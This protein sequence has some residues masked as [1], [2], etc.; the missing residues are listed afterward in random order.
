MVRDQSATASQ[1]AIQSAMTHPPLTSQ[2][3]LA[4]AAPDG[5]FK[6]TLP[7][8]TAATTGSAN[9]SFGFPSVTPEASTAARNVVGMNPKSE[10]RIKHNKPPALTQPDVRTN[11]FENLL[12]PEFAATQFDADLGVN[13]QPQFVGGNGGEVLPSIPEPGD[14]GFSASDALEYFPALLGAPSVSENEPNAGNSTQTADIENWPTLQS[15]EEI[16]RQENATS[17]AALVPKV[18]VN[19]D[20]ETPRMPV[21]QPLALG[22]TVQREGARSHVGRIVPSSVEK[23]VSKTVNATSMEAPLQK[24]LAANVS[25]SGLSVTGKDNPVE[26]YGAVSRHENQGN[27]VSMVKTVSEDQV[28]HFG[29]SKRTSEAVKYFLNAEQHSIAFSTTGSTLPEIPLISVPEPVKTSPPLS[30]K[31][32]PLEYVDPAKKQTTTT[33]SNLAGAEIPYAAYSDDEELALPVE[34]AKVTTYRFAAATTEE[35]PE[36]THPK[37]SFRSSESSN[38]SIPRPVAA[39]AQISP[40]PPLEDYVQLSA[41]SSNELDDKPPLEHAPQDV[42]YIASAY[43]SNP[44]NS[45]GADLIGGLNREPEDSRKTDAPLDD[46]ELTVNPLLTFTTEGK[47]EVNAI[48]EPHSNGSYFRMEFP[49]A[50]PPSAVLTG[51]VGDIIATESISEEPMS[52]SPVDAGVEQASN[53][54]TESYQFDL[55]LGPPRLRGLEERSEPC[56]AEPVLEGAE[57]GM[58]ELQREGVE[59]TVDG[60]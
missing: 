57:D 6:F 50:S 49:S 11:F 21:S 34:A 46:G 1:P 2:T 59:G 19:G 27:E 25:K 40:P 55:D 38:D 53:E 43:D 28:F 22:S 9:I 12:L 4:N 48:S 26:H 44:F 5:G 42:L 3:L 24:D 33:T 52:A 32:T 13:C 39:T 7:P 31:T 8:T 10:P 14:L 56:A 41:P 17:Q 18:A 47:E 16:L 60:V 29:V 15:Y 36:Q 30:N 23:A 37:E 35:G 54:P 45:E 20:I 58:Q 51:P